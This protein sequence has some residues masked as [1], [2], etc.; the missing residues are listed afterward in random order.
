LRGEHREIFIPVRSALHH[1]TPRESGNDDQQRENQ[2]RE[3]I[4]HD[5]LRVPGWNVERDYS[6]QTSPSTCTGGL[7]LVQTVLTFEPCVK[8]FLAYL[9]HGKRWKNHVCGQKLAVS[10]GLENL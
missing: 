7:P 9:A 4:V 3:P 5:C 6:V 10:G 1:T 2:H 8:V